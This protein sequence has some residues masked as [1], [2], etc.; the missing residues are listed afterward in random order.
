MHRA[1]LLLLV[2]GG[3][4]LQRHR[5]TFSSPALDELEHAVDAA[6]LPGV[7]IESLDGAARES[8]AV[9]RRLRAR[10]DSFAKNGDC[11]RCWLQRAH[12]V[13][14]RCAPLGDLGS[15]RRLFVVMHHKEILL[16]V[17]TAKLLLAAYPDRARLVVGGLAGQPAEAE[18]LASI[19]AGEAIVLFP[20][21]DSV[22]ASALDG[23]PRDVVVLDGTWSQARKLY[24]R[25]PVAPAVRLDAADVDE[26]ATGAGRQLRTHP[27]AWREVS[28]LSAVRRLLTALGSRTA[29]ALSGYQD[30]ADAAA[31]R[32]LGPPRLKHTT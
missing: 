26:L 30:V 11:R 16:A 31:R 22:P 27:T 12:C 2:A 6:L 15:A 13:C 25:L 1:L 28:T 24:K 21:D 7:P 10:M 20:S 17:D 5:P 19:A 3:R 4:A 18:M 8:V 9:A 32:Q 23:T 29:G 14:D